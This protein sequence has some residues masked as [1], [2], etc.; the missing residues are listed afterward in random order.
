MGK[1]NSIENYYL[2]GIK[3]YTR[4]FEI[5]GWESDKDQCTRFN[6][7]P[8]NTDPAG[9]QLLDVGCGTGTLYSYL[10]CNEIE[11]TYTG[12]DILPEMA[13]LAR[14]R[15]PEGTFL[16]ADLFSGEPVPGC[17]CD[18]LFSS[19]IFNI[20]LG[21]NYRFLGEAL[22]VFE[23]YAREQIIINLL[24]DASTD[25]EEGYFY[26]A[27]DRVLELPGERGNVRIVDN[28]LPNDFTLFF[29]H[30]VIYT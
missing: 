26:Y 17:E 13:A 24:S 16:C 2:P 27:K 12:V 5:H 23:E 1:L 14:E 6:V 28:Y 10:L 18:V 11:C 8:D 3:K 25:K 4:C 15:H 7:F 19:G 22:K 30:K 21:N 9:K 20:D 29:S